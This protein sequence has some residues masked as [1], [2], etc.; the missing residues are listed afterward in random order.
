MICEDGSG[1][2][3]NGMVQNREEGWGGGL[4]QRGSTASMESGYPHEGNLI[5]LAWTFLP[6]TC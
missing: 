1:H 2:L 6:Y 3:L 5:K 4:S